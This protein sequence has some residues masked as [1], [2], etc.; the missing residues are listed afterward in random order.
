MRIQKHEKNHIP[1]FGIV[2]PYEWYCKGKTVITNEINVK[3][4]FLLHLLIYFLLQVKNVCLL[5]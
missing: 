2:L 3:L 4:L 1:V 5:Q